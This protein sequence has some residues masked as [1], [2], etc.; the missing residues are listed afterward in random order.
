MTESTKSAAAATLEQY[1]IAAIPET[2][3]HGRPRDLFTIWFSSNIM[4]LTFVTGAL[5]PVA[6]KL[7]FAASILAIL[8]GNLVGALFM[9]LHS[10]QGPRLGVPQM[11]QSRGQYGMV[12]AVLVIA[13]AVFMYVGFFA[14]NLI[15][16][17]QSINQLASSVSTDWGIVIC[18]IG[19]LLITVFGYDMI[20]AVNRWATFLFGGAML[21]AIIVIVARGLPAGFFSAGSFSWSGFIG[22]AATTG[23][24][25]QIAY[26]PYVSDYSR[27]MPARESVRA[28]F[29][30]SYWG[31]V[32]GT[33]LPMIV[34][35]VVGLAS[36]NP[37]QIGAMFHLT[38]GIGWLIMLVFALG[39]IDTNS[40]NLYGGMLCSITV[41][42]T[43]RHTWLPRALTRGVVSGAIVVVSLIGAL[44]YQSTFLTSYVNFILFLLYVLIPWTAINLVDFYLIRHGDYDVPSFFTPSGG[45]YGRVNWATLLVY[46]IGIGVEIP[47][48]NTTMY[49]GPVAKALGGTDISWVVGLVIVIPLYYAVARARVSREVSAVVPAGNVSA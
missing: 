25:W 49:E 39:I 17:G 21:L 48:V 30:Y 32:L 36:A 12:G 33:V 13:I 19:S 1:T 11:I 14:S 7:S 34:G 9:A 28:T 29:W 10:A 5:A 26:A 45:I 46:L 2:E 42:Q 23:I 40:I 22:A 47:F 8:I 3:R 41:G 24:L 44:A 37:N 4:P 6:F 27:Y 20:H 43:F 18:A 35:V 38:A 31:V 16:G 15:L